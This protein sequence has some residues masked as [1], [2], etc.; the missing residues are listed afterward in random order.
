MKTRITRLIAT[1]ILHHEQLDQRA[2]AI[3]FFINVIRQLNELGNWNS[4]NVIT[5][6]L[7]CPPIVRLKDTWRKITFN[8]AEEYCYFIQVSEDLASGQQ[9]E[10]YDSL[11]TFL[12]IFDDVA[13]KI[14]ERCGFKI[15]QIHQH[16]LHSSWDNTR[17]DDIMNWVNSEILNI[18]KDIK[19]N[20]EDKY[21][22]TKLL[23]KKSSITSIDETMKPL[24][25]TKKLNIFH[26][27]FNC[28]LNSKC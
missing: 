26:R 4:I 27:F 6:S 28:P 9:L 7:Q 1:Y 14:K 8:N 3:L 23:G 10:C 22:D 5:Q 13:D 12:A 21:V 16:R 11:D 18:L 24:K 15:L 25:K 2:E 19:G 20:V 17:E